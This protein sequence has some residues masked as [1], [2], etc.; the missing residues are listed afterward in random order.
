MKTRDFPCGSTCAGVSVHAEN[1]ACVPFRCT[2]KHHIHDGTGMNGL[3]STHEFPY[4]DIQGGYF[5]RSIQYFFMKESPRAS[6][7]R[8]R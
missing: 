3:G 8:I 5:L 7:K 2:A 1:G 4:P 6:R